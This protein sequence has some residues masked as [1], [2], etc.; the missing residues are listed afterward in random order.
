MMA[1]KKAIFWDNDGVL[2]DTER[3]YFE[4]NRQI[5]KKVGFELTKAL[6]IELYLTKSKGAWHLLDHEKYSSDYILNLRQERD[7]LFNEF[8]STKEIWIDGIEDIVAALSERYRMAIVTSS[9]PMH[10]NAIHSRTNLLKYFE[11]VIGPDDYT[12]Y[13][14]DPEPYLVA[15]ERMSVGSKEGIAIE[16]SRRG[17]LSAK[18]AGLECIMVKNELTENSDFSQADYVLTNIGNLTQ[19]L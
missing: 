10:F 2:V 15:I 18:A 19:I 17:L 3:Y 6:Y 1:N 12:K 13:K 14:P 4:A 11:F 5:L 16:D 9:K 7:D 8:L